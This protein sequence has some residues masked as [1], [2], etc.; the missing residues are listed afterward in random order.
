MTMDSELDPFQTPFLAVAPPEV[1]DVLR[2]SRMKS[3]APV[4]TTGFAEG[5]LGS[6]VEDQAVIPIMDNPVAV[7]A[8]TLT[9]HLW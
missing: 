6:L 7:L 3:T 8:H 4:E 5:F 9:H 2:C 1:Q